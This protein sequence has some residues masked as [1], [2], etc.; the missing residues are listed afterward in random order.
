[1]IVLALL[2][3]AGASEGAA[4]LAPSPSLFER[5]EPSLEAGAQALNNGDVD[6]AI[7]RFRHAQPQTDDQRAIVEYDVGAALLVRAVASKNTPAPAGAPS[8]HATG[9]A[10]AHTAADG[11]PPAESAP[12]DTDDAR[13]AFERAYGIAGDQRLKS[14]AALAAGNAA[15]FGGKLDDAIE[16]YR[17]AVVAD[18]TNARA[19]LNLRRALEAKRAQPPPPPHEGDDDKEGD[20]KK[21]EP[22][23]DEEKG[24][25]KK[26]E[27]KPAAGENNKRKLKK[28]EAR[29]LLEMMR[30]RERPLTPMEMRGQ[31]QAQTPKQGKDW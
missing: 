17:K 30:A 27:P 20:D 16:Q 31:E 12:P 28:E 6:D 3:C 5:A 18:A 7:E 4:A 29:R 11:A 13:A 9:Q 1:M 14:E 23:P 8:A 26:D 10:G 2:L 19:K 24:D 25:D 22:K 21:D 15:A